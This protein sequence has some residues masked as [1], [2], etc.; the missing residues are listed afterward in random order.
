MN[1][2]LVSMPTP[3]NPSRVQPVPPMALL[4]IA[5]V[6]IQHNHT[7]E[8]VD[9]DMVETDVPPDNNKKIQAVCEKIKRS[10]Y[11]IVGINCLVSSQFPISRALSDAT[12]SIS[13]DIVVML[14]GMHATLFA[15]EI[16]T[17]CSSFDYIILGE[18]E[19]QT[20]DII[21]ALE[22][23]GKKIKPGRGIAWRGA[24]NDVHVNERAPLM[25][26]ALLPRPAWHLINIDDYRGDYSKWYNPKHNNITVV[27]PIYTSRSC[28][29]T[30]TFCSAFHM[31][32]KGLRLRK[33]DSI[34]DEIDFLYHEYNINYFSIFDDNFTLNRDHV[35]NFCAAIRA[36]KLNIQFDSSS[37][38]NL[39]ALD[40]YTVGA[41]AE[42]GCVHFPMPIESGDD[43]IRQKIIKK[44]LPREKIFEIAALAKKNDMLT[45]GMFI[46]GFPEETQ[47]SLENTKHMI[48]ELELD[49]YH[50]YTLI[51]FPGTKIFNQALRDNL[52]IGSIDIATLWRGEFNFEKPIEDFT[53]RPYNLSMETLRGYRKIFDQYW[54]KSA[55]IRKLNG[56]SDGTLS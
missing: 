46:I 51:P 14:G 47:E 49:K 22:N 17:N 19:S 9:M 16:L 45:T 21:N 25:D 18:G 3:Y 41:L 52:F 5:A 2:L 1:I 33:M 35:L 43:N 31:M 37:G 36:R 26:L 29:L 32:G 28:P 40:E 8:I 20:I 56:C 30:C 24:S 34:I 48:E 11:D 42:A 55:R 53:I 50:V 27:A 6:L 54:F 13:S 44:N 38:F 23:N 4:S 10:K 12:K 15:K 39:A 7:V